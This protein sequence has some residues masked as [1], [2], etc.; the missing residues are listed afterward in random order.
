[1]KGNKRFFPVEHE[2]Y[3]NSEIMFDANKLLMQENRSMKNVIDCLMDKNSLQADL[4]FMDWTFFITVAYSHE[5]NKKSCY[6][7]MNALYDELVAK[8]DELAE[9][10]IFFTTEAFTNRK[11]YHNHFVAYCSDKK[12]HEAIQQDIE[13]YFDG[14]RLHVE[15]YNRYEAGL[16][17]MVKD[18]LV[19]EDWDILG[20]RLSET[21][22]A[23]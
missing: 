15:P 1:M 20:N 6:R 14:N 17:Y 2:K 23:T 8:Y 12:L 4:W 22:K 18:G 5:R 11:G 9:V 19:N 13:N 10:R 7:M 3:F 16:F 21:V